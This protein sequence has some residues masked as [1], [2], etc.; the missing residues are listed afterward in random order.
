[1]PQVKIHLSTALA[2]VDKPK[3]VK[4][5]RDCMPRILGI[6]ENIGQV[7]LYETPPECRSI[8]AGRDPNFVFVEISMYPGRTPEKKQALTGQCI[9]VIRQYTRVKAEDIVC[10][11]SEIAPENYF[12]GTSH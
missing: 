1:M 7:L 4:E 6:P 3:L 12:S 10:A 8:H 9:E 2:Q 11:I 5:I